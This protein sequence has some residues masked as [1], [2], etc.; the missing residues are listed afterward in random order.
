MR[1]SFFRPSWKLG[2][3]HAGL[4][5]DAVSRDR[6]HGPNRYQY[7]LALP[8]KSK[9]VEG[10][11]GSEPQAVGFCWSVAVVLLQPHRASG[12][13]AL[14]ALDWVRRD[15]QTP[16]RDSWGAEHR[17]QKSRI[18][19]F[20]QALYCRLQFFLGRYSDSSYPPVSLLGTFRSTLPVGLSPLVGVALQGFY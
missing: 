15:V 16:I 19:G 7:H 10:P 6:W 5:K 18:G 11:H 9:T 1:S 8:F 17:T 20:V 12:P 2:I 4:W 13:A 3:I 14:S